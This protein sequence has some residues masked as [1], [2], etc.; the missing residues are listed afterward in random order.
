MPEP[1]LPV[2][3]AWPCPDDHGNGPDRESP[4]ASTA[5]TASTG[6][7]GNRL[8]SSLATFAAS[9]EAENRPHAVWTVLVATLE[10]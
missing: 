10:D 3:P 4:T 7:R 8:D 1:A 9:D 2:L 5:S 6:R